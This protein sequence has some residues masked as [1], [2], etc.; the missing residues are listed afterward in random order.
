MP[1]LFLLLLLVI[2]LLPLL[3]LSPFF[4]ILI[5]TKKAVRLSCLNEMKQ[6]INQT[7]IVEESNWMP[8][9]VKFQ[10]RLDSETNAE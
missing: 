6:D 4:D 2:L 9:Y 10:S 1:L 8:Y 5:E 7:Q 3:F